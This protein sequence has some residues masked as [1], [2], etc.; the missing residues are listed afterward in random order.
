MQIDALQ[1]TSTET[2]TEPQH[3]LEVELCTDVVDWVNEGVQHIVEHYGKRLEKIQT[4]ATEE[5]LDKGPVYSIEF[6]VLSN[7]EEVLALA[8]SLNLDVF[9]IEPVRRT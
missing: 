9:N 6:V 2:S 3:W 5:D 8:R 7:E 1:G 4:L